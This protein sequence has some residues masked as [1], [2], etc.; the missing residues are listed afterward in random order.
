MSR[1]YSSSLNQWCP[2]NRGKLNRS[3]GNMRRMSQGLGTLATG[4]VLVAASAILATWMTDSLDR[5]GTQPIPES[6]QAYDLCVN[7][8][9]VGMDAT[10]NML[11]DLA[12]VVRARTQ[13]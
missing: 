2:L 8:E 1:P 7:T 11:A 12:G 6:P 9:T 3:C 10:V 13:A 4:A 5:D